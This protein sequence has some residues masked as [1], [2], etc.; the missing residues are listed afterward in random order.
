MEPHWLRNWPPWGMKWS[1]RTAEDGFP[2]LVVKRGRH[3]LR[4][5]AFSSVAYLDDT[6]FDLG[7]VAVY[8]DK[9]DTFYLPTALAEK[10]G[11]RK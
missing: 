2:E 9:N 7:S 8:I 5:P 3:E 6:P 10:L 4:V 11:G 1:V